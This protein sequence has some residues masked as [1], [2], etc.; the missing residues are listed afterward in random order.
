MQLIIYESIVDWKENNRT[1]IAFM[2]TYVDDQIRYSDLYTP[3]VT[4]VYKRQRQSS[5]LLVHFALVLSRP[6]P[7]WNLRSESSTQIY[8]T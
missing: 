7:S 2:K 3:I 8:I 4:H 1:L 5:P 6:S